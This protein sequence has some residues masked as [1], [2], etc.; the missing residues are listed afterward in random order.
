[1]N[2]IL[3]PFAAALLLFVLA[4]ARVQAQPGVPSRALDTTSFANLATLSPSEAS[5]A[6]SA[7]ATPTVV[8]VSTPV[9]KMDDLRLRY[10][11]EY[12]RSYGGGGFRAEKY[13]SR[14][15]GS[16]VIV[17]T[18]G[19]ILTNNHVVDG[20][21]EDSVLV[22]LH[23]GR[24][25]YADVVGQDERTDLALLRIYA[26]GLNAAQFAPDGKIHIGEWVLAL[27]SP[28]GLRSTVTFG[29][30]SA[31]N[32]EIESGNDDEYSIS[33]YIQTDAAINPGNSGGGLFNLQGK[34]VGI[35]TAIYSSSG[36]Y[37]GYGF[38]M[39]VDVAR[40]VAED[41]IADGRLDRGYLGITARNISDTLAARLYLDSQKGAVVEF[42]EEDSPASKG[43][44]LR[45]D[46]VVMVNGVEVESLQTL[47]SAL[48]VYQTGEQITVNVIRDGAPQELTIT[49]GSDSFGDRNSESYSTPDGGLGI[50]VRSLEGADF[51]KLELPGSNG[52]F[53]E[54][55]DP[56]G[57]AYH[58]RLFAGDVLTRINE[59]RVFSMQGLSDYL[60]SRKAGEEVTL[61]V[62]RRGK[63]VV[64]KTV[65]QPKR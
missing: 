38:A 28:L 40:S 18:D 31:L 10:L 11:E 13:R 30:V 35:N 14:S 48:A 64:R 33:S 45:D 37:Q 59:D 1:M 26:D 20:A 9:R 6:V 54:R 12:L 56:Y 27:G 53:I 34:L 47:K 7:I 23:D 65:I 44:L 62:W 19:Y 42:V 61:V 51:E 46:V 15:I 36:F 57:T 4:Q 22:T 60:A 25:F 17:N 55:I 39:P 3:I 32:R 21:Y 58:A 49:L 52:L 2:R 5:I 63:E 41:L 43:G 16:G 50:E 8:S 29:I 24:S